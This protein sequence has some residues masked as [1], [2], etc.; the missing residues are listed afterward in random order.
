VNPEH[1]LDVTGFFS[2]FR[3]SSHCCTSCHT[4]DVRKRKE[5][6]NHAN[7][8]SFMDLGSS[9]GSGEGQMWAYS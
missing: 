7:E 3:V 6:E 9:A 1:I 4:I 8:G 5:K 2:S